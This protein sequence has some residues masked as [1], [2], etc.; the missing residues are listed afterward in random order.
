MPEYSSVSGAYKFLKINN[1]KLIVHNFL[2]AATA[3]DSSFPIAVNYDGSATTGNP[4]TYTLDTVPVGNTAFIY[5]TT[6]R[7]MAVTAFSG[8]N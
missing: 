8:Y 7:K 6:D 3:G 1:V 4:P 2:N 5:A